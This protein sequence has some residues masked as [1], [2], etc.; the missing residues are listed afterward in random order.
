MSLFKR[1]AAE[2]AIYGISSIVGRALYFLLTPL[3]TRILDRSIYSETIE[4]FAYTALVMV[5]FTYRMETAFFRFGA[6]EEE[7]KKAFDT[8]ALSLLIS[9]LVFSLVLLILHQPIAG[10][11]GYAAHSEYIAI[12]ALI[13]LFDALS[14]IPYAKLRLEKKA[15][16]FARIRLTNIITNIAFNLFFL[17]G[18]PYIIGNEAFNFLHPFISAIYHPDWAIGYIFVSNLIASFVQFLLLIPQ[19]KGMSFQTDRILW[20]IMFLYAAPLVVASLA[21]VINEVFDKAL[22][23]WRLPFDM[24]TNKSLLG[25]YGAVYKLT[26]II[27][28]FSQA[29]RY[30]AEPFFFRNSDRKD[31][32][33]IYADVTRYFTLFSLLG[34][35]VIACYIDIFKYLIGNEYWNALHIVPILLMA[36]VFLGIYYNVSIWYRLTDQTSYG[37]YIGVFGAIITIVLNWVWIPE[38]GYTGSA[39][40]TFLCYFLMTILCYLF[41]RRYY[42]IPYPL[43]RLTLYLFLATGLV[44]ISGLVRESDILLIPQLLIQSFIIILYVI[45]CVLFEHKHIKKVLAMN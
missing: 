1:L 8:G 36:N 38:W 18:C 4:L 26:I 6:K 19:Y 44:Y 35:L 32:K 22:L 20:K 30:S 37:L 27:S 43:L 12:L 33:Q 45:L 25:E 11:L 3:Y 23:K 42:N 7:R 28:L 15:L 14:E 9:S 13:I 41:G 39:W 24:E 5:V 34:F 29:F 40:A 10:I 2:T 17:L 21:G 16:N 31:S